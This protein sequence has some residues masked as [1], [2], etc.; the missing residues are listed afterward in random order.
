MTTIRTFAARILLL[1]AILSLTACAG[2]SRRDQNMVVGA[3]VGAVAGAVLAGG[4]VATVGG[5]A[6]GAVIGHE[7]GRK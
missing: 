5:A 7:V 6:V 3:G 2:L 1:S 4:A